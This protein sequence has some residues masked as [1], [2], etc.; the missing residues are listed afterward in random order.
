MERLASG[1][2]RRGRH[3]RRHRG[4]SHALLFKRGVHYLCRRKRRDIKQRPSTIITVVY[5]STQP[6]ITKYSWV[7]VSSKAPAFCPLRFIG[8]WPMSA[9]KTVSDVFS[10]RRGKKKE[11][12]NLGREELQGRMDGGRVVCAHCAENDKVSET[13]CLFVRHNLTEPFHPRRSARAPVLKT[14]PLN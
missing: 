12:N 6:L 11:Q 5:K 1:G 9:S 2:S 7:S 13:A 14:I 10:A 3:I 8:L 4:L